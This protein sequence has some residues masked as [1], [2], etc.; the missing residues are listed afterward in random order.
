MY[1]KIKNT[2]IHKEI[3]VEIFYLC[4][5]FLCFFV[6]LL[7]YFCYFRFLCIF[8]YVFFYLLFWQ[9]WHSIMTVFRQTFELI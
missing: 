5:S 1:K 4:F 6:D 7:I 2:I 8:I 9:L 3:K